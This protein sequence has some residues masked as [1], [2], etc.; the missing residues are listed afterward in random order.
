VPRVHLAVTHDLAPEQTRV[1]VERAFAHYRSK[2]AQY[3]PSLKWL[4]AS[5]AEV[6]FS[7]K[8]V[9]VRGTL[10]LRADRIVMDAKVPI[11]LRP[12]TKKAVAK[13]ESEM[14]KWL[15]EAKTLG[16]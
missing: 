6:A 8:G 12:F 1:A 16:G 11:L 15:G 10:E 9:V 4:D 13:V 2:Y 14:A 7:A 3:K 5:R